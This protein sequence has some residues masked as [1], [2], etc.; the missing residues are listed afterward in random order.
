VLLATE[1][2]RLMEASLL[3]D[4]L[5][6]IEEVAREEAGALMGADIGRAGAAIGADTLLVLLDE[7]GSFCKQ[8]QERS[9][10][11]CFLFYVHMFCWLCAIVFFFFQI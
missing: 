10:L 4:A 8:N 5:E 3:T 6:A 2:G 7:A 1:L 11:I 9:H